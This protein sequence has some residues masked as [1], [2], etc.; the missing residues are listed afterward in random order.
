MARPRL[1]TSHH[2]QT[3]PGTA[4]NNSDQECRHVCPQHRQKEAPQDSGQ[5]GQG[6]GTNIGGQIHRI[7]KEKGQPECEWRPHHHCL[8]RGPWVAWARAGSAGCQHL[9]LHRTTQQPS[10]PLSFP[11]GWP[12][13]RRLL[14]RGNIHL[15][16]RLYQLFK[17]NQLTSG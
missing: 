8:E 15:A 11:S 4:V 17:M 7:R 10:H 1:K 3:P 16:W 6:G 5:Q 9:G 13:G 14:C 12:A 2:P